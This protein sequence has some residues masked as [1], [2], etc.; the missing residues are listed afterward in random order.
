[1][2]ALVTDPSATLK[3]PPATD[4]AAKV[5]A[6]LQRDYP[7]GALSWIATLKWTGPTR[8]PVTQ[9]DRTTGTTDWKAAA[10]D[11]AKLA[12]FRT[13]IGAGFRKPVI[14]IRHPGSA[15]LFAVDGHSRVIASADLH[16]P[17]AAYVGTATTAHGPWEQAH[18]RQLAN[19]GAAIDLAEPERVPPGQ[20]EGGKFAV[21]PPVL[22][23]YATPQETADAVNAMGPD[24]RA[25][26]R[27]SVLEPPGFG[28][29]KDDRLAE[30][31]Q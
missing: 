24:Q 7:P 2:P 12:L 13:K 23:R 30:A 17:V 20:P 3:A 5:T 14:L 26:C 19:D 28:W 29:Q 18:S 8:V 4:I 22:T 25:M 15:R 9:I 16:L 21:R 27:R 1:M 31:R 6:Q 11:K 10:A